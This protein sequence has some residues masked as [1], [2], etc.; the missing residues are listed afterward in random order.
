MSK[1]AY[2][3]MKIKEKGLTGKAAQYKRASI[4]TKKGF[5]AFKLDEKAKAP[6]KQKI[7]A[8]DRP[9]IYLEFMGTRL[10]VNQ[11]DGGSVVEADIPFT[12][13]ASLKFNGCDGNLKFS[14]IKVCCAYC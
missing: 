3:E 4:T 11:D 1:D 9:D 5:N 13:G 6:G 8:Q 10:K 2:C 7:E 14:D 12:K